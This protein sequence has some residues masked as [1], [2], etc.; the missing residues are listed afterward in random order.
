MRLRRLIFGLIL[1]L[2]TAGVIAA[3]ISDL[4]GIG[5]IYG[6][7]LYGLLLFAAGLFIGSGISKA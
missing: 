3:R 6:Y 7:P 1:F 5:D 4:F 2:F